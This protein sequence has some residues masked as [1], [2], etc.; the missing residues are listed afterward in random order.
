[1]MERIKLDN[2]KNKDSN[3]END[4]FDS[5]NSIEEKNYIKLLKNQNIIKG[6]DL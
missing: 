3:I 5:K 6:K 2:G 1:M 4:N